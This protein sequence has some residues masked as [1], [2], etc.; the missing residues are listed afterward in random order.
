MRP[1]EVLD[2]QAELKRLMGDAYVHGYVNAFINS[3]RS[4]SHHRHLFPQHWDGALFCKNESSRLTMAEAF[5][6]TDDMCD[7]VRWA[8]VSL[9][10]GHPFY[11]ETLP[12]EYGFV[13]FDKPTRQRDIHGKVT[14]T[15]AVTWGRTSEPVPAW[16]ADTPL[17]DRNDDN[18]ILT[19][20]QPGVR[21]NFYNDPTDMDDYSN[22]DIIERLGVDKV[23]R[24]GRL[25]LQ[26]S[27]FY[28]F[29]TKT[30]QEYDVEQL[31][32]VDTPDD[33]PDTYATAYSA[34]NY[35]LALWILLGQTVTSATEADIDRAA[36]KRAGRAA[37]PPKVTVIT[38]RRRA[39]GQS[40][41]ETHVEWTHRWIVRGHWRNQYYP[42]ENTN[43]L[44][45]IAPYV[46]GP[47]DAPLIQSQKV[48]RLA[49]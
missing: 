29:G 30:V 47:D 43:R 13:W 24:G 20:P 11:L 35:V 42:S 32:D 37:I 14:T 38:L 9:P 25:Q 8:A 3:A 15:R 39:S 26:H 21:L 4:T 23:L 16:L 17:E 46:K 31:I 12:T 41:G 45:W 18:V 6:V 28:S 33:V 1:S 27:F 10:E 22:R 48:Y 36:R 49:R 2:Q 40:E 5:Q 19:E 44:I 7:L 34:F